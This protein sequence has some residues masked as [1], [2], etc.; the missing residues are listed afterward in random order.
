[1]S[2]GCYYGP[3]ETWKIV[4]IPNEMSGGRRGVALVEADCQ[5]QALY[6]FSQ[7]YAGQYQTVET[8]KKLLG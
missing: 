7:Q 5:Q 8:C 2:T 3:M 1:M 6:S 4:Y